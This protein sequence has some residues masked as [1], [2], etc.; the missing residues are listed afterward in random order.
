VNFTKK[1]GGSEI[2]S[3]RLHVCM[4]A[5]HFHPPWNE[6]YQNSLKCLVE[7]ISHKVSI[8]VITTYDGGMTE[9]VGN[10]RIYYLKVPSFIAQIR[11]KRGSNIWFDEVYDIFRFSKIA[12][13]LSPDI[14]HI[15]NVRKGINSYLNS[16]AKVVVQVSKRLENISKFDYIDRKM[17][18]ITKPYCLC[19]SSFLA[20][21]CKN[22]CKWKRIE[23][24][25]PMIDTN[26][27]I[28][29]DK[30]KARIKLILKEK[31]NSNNNFI[32]DDNDFLIG[33]VGRATPGRGVMTLIEA[34]NN[35]IKS[36]KL[37]NVKLMLAFS[38][39]ICERDY[40]QKVER[41]ARQK[42]GN[43]LVLPRVKQPL[44]H[45]YN[46]LDL[47]VVPLESCSAVDPPLTMLESMSCGTPVIS[48]DIGSA[49]EY[50]PQRCIFPCKDSQALSNMIET[51]SSNRA[52]TRELGYKLRER[53]SCNSIEKLKERYL[54]FYFSI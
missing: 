5:H 3:D 6:G 2:S 11:A 43:K 9:K 38:D 40:R 15:Q 17:L 48:S 47:L 23:V 37:E 10:A 22:I 7:S 21:E 50:L 16:H 36:R 41:I 4:L 45:I 46:S 51:F 8:T 34:F 33:Y 52:D 12:R 14:V 1:F 30:K 35:F 28:P 29:M 26:R 49:K 32:L 19:T 44:E 54:E 39:D 31:A 53:I 18:S 25:P 13:N 20:K 42:L 24:I 27:Y